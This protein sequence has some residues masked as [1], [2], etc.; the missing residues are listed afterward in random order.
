MLR[1]IF[2]KMGGLVGRKLDEEL[3]DEWEEQLILSDVSVETATVL[4][5][6]TARRRAARPSSKR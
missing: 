3:L 1:G 5:D 2:Q 4:V 6:E